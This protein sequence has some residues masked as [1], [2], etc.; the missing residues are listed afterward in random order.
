ML[1]KPL[2]FQLILADFL[3]P[4]ELFG[5]LVS[6]PKLDAYGAWSPVASALA[7]AAALA[8]FAAAVYDFSKADY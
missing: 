4:G 5:R 8:L 6:T 3:N 7:S 2:D 1:P